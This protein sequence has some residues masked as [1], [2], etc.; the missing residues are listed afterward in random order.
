MNVFELSTS[1]VNA[2]Y[3]KEKSED[4]DMGELGFKRFKSQGEEIIGNVESL[5]EVDSQSKSPIPGR[6]SDLG[7]NMAQILSLS[8]LLK[9]LKIDQKID[10][11]SSNQ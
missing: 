11:Y 3:S 5:I 8:P 7:T 6:K 4:H 1:S 10:L 9:P 2:V